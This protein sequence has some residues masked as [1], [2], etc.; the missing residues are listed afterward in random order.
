MRGVAGAMGAGGYG[1]RADPAEPQ[2]QEVPYESRFGVEREAETAVREVQGEEYAAD[3][4]W[5]PGLIQLLLR[6]RYPDLAY[7]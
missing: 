2:V 3:M 6:S 7:Q 4:L 5:F 1:K